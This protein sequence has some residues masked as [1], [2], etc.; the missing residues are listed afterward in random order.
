MKNLIYSLFAGLIIAPQAF[1]LSISDIP[2]LPVVK[3]VK[4][5]V[6]MPS[7]FTPVQPTGF[8]QFEHSSCSPASFNVE[9]ER[10]GRVTVVAILDAS[11]MDC[12]GPMI[13]RDYTVQYSSDATPSDRVTVLNPQ[14]ADTE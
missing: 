11:G 5:I 8:I 14:Y 12:R 9:V 4:V 13:A 3:N 7:N 6:N 1:A 10:V 2:N